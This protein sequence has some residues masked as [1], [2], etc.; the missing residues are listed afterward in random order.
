MNSAFSE[1][2]TPKTKGHSFLLLRVSEIVNE[3]GIDIFFWY[4][5]RVF[6]ENC[7]LIVCASSTGSVS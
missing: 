1:R 2:C 6:L 7:A 4:S 3:T 5:F